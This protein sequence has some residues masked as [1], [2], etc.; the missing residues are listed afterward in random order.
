LATPTELP[1]A[2]G[3]DAERRRLAAA[4]DD[5]LRSQ[6]HRL[7]RRILLHGL[8]AV[9][10]VPTAAVLLFFLL[11]RTLRLPA[12]IRVFHTLVVFSLLAAA[13]WW[14]VRRPLRQRLQQLDVAVLIERVFPELHQQ[15]V[16]AVQLEAMLQ[17]GALR[18]QSAAMVERLVASAAA[19]RA[20][21]AAAARARPALHGAQLG[22]RPAPAGR[23][24]HR[25]RA[26]SRHGLGV[27]A[28]A[29]GPRRRLSQG[30]QPGGRTAARR[31]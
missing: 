11:D 24:L 13:T 30:H 28:A 2:A 15:L 17:Q 12:P 1:I 29:T 10:A 5:L 16:S 20:A 8:G 27:P 7:R 3:D 19:A 18:N 4:I 6:L 9:L 21:A 26:R 23:T 22:R 14:F 25:R 31:R